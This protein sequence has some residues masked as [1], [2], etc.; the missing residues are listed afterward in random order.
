MKKTLLLLFCLLTAGM[1]FANGGAES[2]ASEEKPALKMLGAAGDFNP[3]EYPVADVIKRVTGYDVE[4]FM[5]PQDNAE[6]KLNLEL[7]SGADYDLVKYTQINVLHDLI[8]KKAFQPIGG[9][10]DQ[11][12][13]R[14]AAIR[15]DDPYWQLSEVDGELYA[16]CSESPRIGDT[17]NS[18]MFPEKLLEEVGMEK[19]ATL[20]EFYDFALAVKEKTGMTPLT[21]NGWCVNPIAAAF[22]VVPQ[23]FVDLGNEIVSQPRQEGMIDY[24]NFMA[25]LY[26]EELIDVEWPIN[27]N[28]TVEEKFLSGK[29][30]MTHQGWYAVPKLVRSFREKVDPQTNLTY[31]AVL[32]R[33]DGSAMLTT[34]SGSPNFTAIPKNAANPEHAMMYL[35]ALYEPEAFKEVVIGQKD[36]HYSV[37]DQ[38][39]TWPIAPAFFDERNNAHFYYSWPQGL[40]YPELWQTRL[41]KD[42]DMFA[43]YNEINA[44]NNEVRTYDPL[45]FAPYMEPVAKY[46]QSLGKMESDFYVKYIAGGADESDWDRFIKDW[47]NSGG[48]E[49]EAAVQQWY[50]SK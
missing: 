28:A 33:D 36:V 47:E 22:N 9:L 10:I 31:I 50:A 42:A 21:G 7:A 16:L 5:L 32:T 14:L 1:L 23:T 2:A 6:Q 11:Y 20:D 24:L 34:V 4:F 46:K 8:A 39:R 37:D 40:G 38:G 35:N 12:A 15:S 48:A 13:P 41:R 43:C 19:P 29:A 18:L 30:A 25:R 17:T 3:N 45:S 26:D 49:M 27:K 44:V